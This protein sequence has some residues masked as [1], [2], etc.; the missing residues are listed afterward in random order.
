MTKKKNN[1]FEEIT[2]ILDND[3][4]G[5]Y[6][7]PLSAQ[8]ALHILCD[9]ILGDDF[10]IVDPLGVEQANTIITKYILDKCSHQFR[11]EWKEHLKET[12]NDHR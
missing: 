5:L 3:E 7:A 12:R 8:K 10:Y 9:Y 2:K 6:P 4:Y 1:S 11:K